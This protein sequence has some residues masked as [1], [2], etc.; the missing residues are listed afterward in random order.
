M[1][2]GPS[3]KCFLGVEV[4]KRAAGK[5]RDGE[6]EIAGGYSIMESV[7]DPR[8]QSRQLEG[9]EKDPNLRWCF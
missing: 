1:A 4:R 7:Q 5:K 2:G 8:R 3:R 9:E 6:W